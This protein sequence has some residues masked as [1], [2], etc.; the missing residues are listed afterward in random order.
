MNVENYGPALSGLWDE[1]VVAARNSTFLHRR[2]YMDYHAHRFEDC[3]LLLRDGKNNVVAL[4]P[5]NRVGDVVFS[6]GGLTCGGLLL[7]AR[8][9]QKA[10][11]EA[12]EG[13]AEH[14]LAQGIR[15]VVYKPVPHIFHRYPAE[16]DLYAL[17]KM[18]AR[19]AS[20]QPS[21]AIELGSPLPFQKGRKS[22]I[23]KARKCGVVLN[24]TS[25]PSDFHALLTAA[26][27]RHKAIPVH[28][29]PE[30]KLLTNRFP[31]FIK[32][33]EARS[34]GRLLAGA[35]IFD[36]SVVAHTQYVAVSEEGRQVGALD[37]LL[38]DLIRNVYAGRRRFS[39]GTSINPADSVLNEGLIAQKEGFGA[40]TVVNDTYEWDLA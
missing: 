1:T 40:R 21:T 31:D 38:A 5:A 13:I 17:F 2:G 22:G 9:T 34:N 11:I 19:L 14:Y 16:E 29:L 25:D 36:F 39:L 27:V 28:S 15:Q 35:L 26:L 37:L 10:C 12:F 4:F 6:H 33:F 3:S 20:R 18:G 30:L 32:L 24:A 8:L 23:N 7:G